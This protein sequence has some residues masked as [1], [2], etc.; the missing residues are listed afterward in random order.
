[1]GKGMDEKNTCG[2][3]AQP[4]AGLGSILIYE[5]EHW[6]IRHANETNILGYLILE[7]KR[8]LLDLS[9][10]DESELLSYGPLLGALM[11]A[12]RSVTDCQRVYTFTLAE[13][14]PHFHV[15]LIPR[16][17]SIPRAYRGRGI[18]SYPLQPTADKELMVQ[19]CDRLRRALKLTGYEM[20]ARTLAPK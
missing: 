14:V 15:H 5:D 17:A 19:T 12:I 2:I 11:K 9:Q 6:R 4:A 7:S 3:C 18:M 13:M 20:A 16:T 10:A 8:H 1:M